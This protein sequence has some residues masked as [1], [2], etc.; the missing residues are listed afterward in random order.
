MITSN[1]CTAGTLALC[2]LYIYIYIYTHIPAYP[3]R[4]LYQNPVWAV[5][6]QITFTHKYIT[7]LQKFNNQCYFYILYQIEYHGLGS[8]LAQVMAWCRQATSHYLNQF[9]PR[10]ISPNGIIQLSNTCITTSC[11]L[12]Y[13][14]S[15]FSLLFS[16]SP[17]YCYVYFLQTRHIQV[18]YG[19][20]PAAS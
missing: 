4:V 16:C 3:H 2:I 1:L 9:W 14:T 17:V 13:R 20:P 11:F 8:T 7:D 12:H 6:I 10:S 5:Y 15:P 19:D 18:L